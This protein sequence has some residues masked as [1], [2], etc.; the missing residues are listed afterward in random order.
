MTAVRIFALALAIVLSCPGFRLYGSFP[1]PPYLQAVTRGGICVLVEATATDTLA[2]VYG[3]TASYGNTARTHMIL[4][5]TGSTYVHRVWISGLAPN[6]LYHYRAIQNADTSD[7]ATFRTAPDPGT[8]FRF[9]W[10]ADS[11]TG[12]AVHEAIARRIAEASPVVSLYGGDIASSPSYAAWKNEFFRPDQLALIARVPFYNAPG[13]HEGWATNTMAFTQTPDTA[14]QALGYFSVDYGDMHVLV[15]NTEVSFSQGSPQ[16]AFAGND[17][18]STTKQWKIVIA[19]K[20]AYCAGGHGENTDLKLMTQAIFELR[21]VD[22]VIGGHSHFYQHNLVKGIHHMVLGSAGAPL[23]DTDSASYTL[24]SAR[25]YSYGIVDVTPG[26]F[27]MMVYNAG[28]AVLDSIILRKPP[29]AKTGDLVLP[30]EFRLYPNYPNPFNPT[31][32]IRYDVP[33]SA[34]V[35]LSVF[36]VL[37]HRVSEEVDGRQEAGRYNV[38]VTGERLSGW[39]YFCRLEA[40]G[41]VLVR[42]LLLLR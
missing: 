34:Y 39:V 25:D 24:K 41:T 1:M 42:K 37:G 30:R 29:A 10:F 35:N 8:P 6:T 3:R 11:R 28:G 9:A 19:H 33:R 38:S 40:A 2:V 18:S 13:N 32:T 36:D 26:T 15:L 5:T 4:M 23:Y 14:S 31:T 16:Y 7:D 17:L 21:S 12:T 22:M 20:P 27:R